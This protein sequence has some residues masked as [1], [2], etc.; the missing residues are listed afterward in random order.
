MGAADVALRRIEAV[1]DISD[2]VKVSDEDLGWLF[3]GEQVDRR[4]RPL[5]GTWPRDSHRHPG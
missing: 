4:G 5:A 2:I 3:P 1:V